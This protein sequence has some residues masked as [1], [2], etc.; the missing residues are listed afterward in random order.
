MCAFISYNHRY[1][2]PTITPPHASTHIPTTKI[3]PNIHLYNI[4]FFVLPLNTLHDRFFFVYDLLPDADD[5][6]I[7]RS[8]NGV[9]DSIAAGVYFCVQNNIL[10]M[11]E[12][13]RLQDCCC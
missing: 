7:V 9:S 3:K 1:I 12:P 4:E 8:A 6:G 2:R 10:M 13:R 5:V 11:I